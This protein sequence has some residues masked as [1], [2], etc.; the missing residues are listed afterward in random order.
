MSAYALPSGVATVPLS[1]FPSGPQLT[2]SHD[3]TEPDHTHAAPVHVCVFVVPARG[4]NPTSHVKVAVE[5]NKALGTDAVALATVATAP[6]L[7]GAQLGALPDHA[8]VTPQ[9]RVA[10]PDNAWPS[11]QV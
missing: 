7:V 4:T 9:V 11:R 2:G 8:P 5:P 1:G 10:L 6:Q 3:N